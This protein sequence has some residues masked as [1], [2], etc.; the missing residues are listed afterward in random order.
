MSRGRR[1]APATVRDADRA[2]A[3]AA[4]PTRVYALA[5]E[6]TQRLHVRRARAA[7]P[8][9]SRALLAAARRAA[10]DTVALLLHNGLQ[11]LRAAARRDVRRLLRQAA[12]PAGAA[13]AAALRARHSDCRL[14]FVAPDWEARGARAARRDRARRSPSSS[15]IRTSRL[16]S[17]RAAA[18]GS[19]TPAPRPDAPALLMYTSGTTGVPKGV[20][21]THGNLAATPRRSAPSTA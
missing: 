11:T 17:D 15:S 5:T 2:Q 19:R 21:L 10:G 6:A 16:R 7:V 13:R 1:A 18:R 4:R 8:A 9:Q 14:V 20:V 3:R 12:Q